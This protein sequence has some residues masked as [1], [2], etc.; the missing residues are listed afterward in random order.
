MEFRQRQPWQSLLNLTTLGFQPWRQHESGAQF[1]NF[2]V[3][4]ET[5][6][7]G[8]QFEQ[9]SAR[10]SEIDRFEIASVYYR[11]NIQSYVHDSFS[12]ALL[13]LP[14]GHTPRDV[15]YRPDRYKAPWF[16]GCMNQINERMP[17][18]VS[19]F[20]LPLDLYAGT[21]EYLS[22]GNPSPAKQVPTK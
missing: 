8:G 11:R 2:F 10:F 4:S 12:P 9:H 14:V 1:I 6:R 21:R 7:I 5:W 20:W 13:L 18:K 3:D 17:G 22:G 15:V 16:V 19:C